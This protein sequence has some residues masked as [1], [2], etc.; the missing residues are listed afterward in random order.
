[1]EIIQSHLTVSSATSLVSP[2]TSSLKIEVNSN[3]A[4]KERC[5][6]WCKWHPFTYIFIKPSCD[7]DTTTSDDQY[8]SHSPPL[9]LRLLLLV[10]LKHSCFLAPLRVAPQR[11]TPLGG[12]GETKRH[13]AVVAS[14]DRGRRGFGAVVSAGDGSFGLCVRCGETTHSHA[15]SVR[16]PKF[17]H[18]GQAGC[19]ASITAVACFG[20]VGCV[21]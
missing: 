13:T 6:T 11:L 2:R 5:C 18:H 15:G 3:R 8:H 7:Y 12:A 20:A 10:L 21:F 1:M 19:S 9:L 17:V 4:K 16:E 14:V